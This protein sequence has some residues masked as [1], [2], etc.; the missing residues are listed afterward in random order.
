MEQGQKHWI[1]AILGE[2]PF[3][4]YPYFYDVV[5]LVVPAP[6]RHGGLRLPDDAAAVGRG[7][8]RDH[9]PG[10]A[11]RCRPRQPGVRVQ[12]GLDAGPRPRDRPAR[13]GRRRSTARR[14]PSPLRRHAVRHRRRARRRRVAAPRPTSRRWPRTR[15]T[16]VYGLPR[17]P[18]AALRD[19]RSRRSR[20]TRAAR[21]R[22]PNPAST[23][24]RHCACGGG[25]LLGAVHARA[26]GRDPARADRRRDRRRDLAAGKLVSDG[27]T[28]FIIPQRTRWRR[29]TPTRRSIQA[30]VNGGGRFLGYYTG[31]TTSARNVGLTALNTQTMTPAIT[32]RARR[33]T[34]RSTRPTRSRGASTRAAG[35]TATSGNA[36]YNPATL[37]GDGDDPGASAPCRTRRSPAASP[38]ATRSTR[39]APASSTAARRSS[40]SR[41]APVARSCSASN[42]F[43]RAWHDG[44]ERLALNALI[45]P[46]GADDPAETRRRPRSP[47]RRSRPRRRSRRPSCRRRSRGRDAGGRN[48]S[49]VTSGS[50]SSATPR[51]GA[52]AAVK[53]AKLSKQAAREG[54]LQ[55]HPDD[56]HAR[57]AQRPR[58]DHARNTWVSPIMHDLRSGRSARCF[59][60]AVADRGPG[61]PADAGP[62][63]SRC[64]SFSRGAG[65]VRSER[66][67]GRGRSSGGP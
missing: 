56:V 25:L 23:A 59:A 1:Q 28:A 12:H 27:F 7:D 54:P 52:K 47:P 37:A 40:T 6:A 21:R 36:V 35:S 55:G 51:R 2:N 45:Y 14:R 8:D 58:D 50:R 3:I 46:L 20:C 66:E 32:R 15:D 13:E 34:A 39:S 42:P 62:P 67:V 61:G 48:A 18:V 30:F 31:G 17:Y 65:L 4:P 22:P 26:E 38:T 11:A 10:A 41:S 44:E 5:H 29:P 60:Q 19:R 63:C 57:H 16:P 49:T 9:R 64:R 33:T 24:R 53:R 43:F